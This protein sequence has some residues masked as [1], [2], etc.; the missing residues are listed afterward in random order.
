VLLP[1]R[2]GGYSLVG[3]RRPAPGL[4]AHPMGTSSVLRETLARAKERALRAALLEI[5]FD[6]DRA[7]DLRWLADARGR[8]PDLECP[9][10]LAWLDRHA[11]WPA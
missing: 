2:D 11:L 10:A 8:D 7:A 9:R 6:V 3:L 1:D 5:G 4:F